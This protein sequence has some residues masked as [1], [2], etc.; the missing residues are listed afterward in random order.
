MESVQKKNILDIHFDEVTRKE[1]VPAIIFSNFL[2]NL[3]KDIECNIIFNFWQEKAKNNKT[4]DLTSI[5]KENHLH[6]IILVESIMV[7]MEKG[8]YKISIED[9]THIL[10]FNINDEIWIIRV[11]L[12]QVKAKVPNMGL[13]ALLWEDILALK[14][15]DLI[16]LVKQENSLQQ[17]AILGTY[18]EKATRMEKFPV[19][20]FSNFLLNLPKDIECDI[21]FNFWREKSKDNKNYDLKSL[22]NNKLSKNIFAMT[23][24]VLKD[25][26]T[27]KI[28]DETLTQ[29]LGFSV[30]K[31]VSLIEKNILAAKQEIP[32][33]E[34][35]HLLEYSIKRIKNS[36]IKYLYEKIETI[37]AS[38][39]IQTCNMCTEDFS[40]QE[41]IYR[42]PCM[43]VFH[44]ACIKTLLEEDYEDQCTYCEE[45]I[46]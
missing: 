34:T 37:I 43:H 11:R 32:K 2:L 42:L 7:F 41:S 29:L 22:Y 4:Y 31:E 33:L 26:F 13:L 5:Y 1:K 35:I 28:T 44:K 14:R 36:Y 45:K 19:V 15:E 12:S 9:L 39:D 25:K 30:N 10:G 21:I 17:K 40:E 23:L 46:I 27:T 16:S 6:R 18:F 20:I 38:Q 24:M 3:P 8:T